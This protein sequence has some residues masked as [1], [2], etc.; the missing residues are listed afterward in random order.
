MN[1]CMICMMSLVALL[2]A[3]TLVGATPVGTA[4]TY[5]GVLKSGGAPV[6]GT[7][8][9]RFQLF[10]AMAGGTQIGA[11][12]DLPTAAVDSGLFSVDLDFG[13][14]PQAFNGSARW[15]Q[16]QVITNGGSTVTTLAP[17][18]PMNATPYALFAASVDGST[19]TN[20]NASNLASG[21]I[22]SAQLA[23][24]YAGALALTNPSNSIAGTF[25]GSGAGL[26][27]LNAS[28]LA[29]GT[30]SGSLLSGTYGNALTLSNA[31]NSFTGSGAGLTE[32]NASNISSGILAFER[33]PGGGAWPLSST[34]SLDS[35]T[36]AIDSVNNRVG[37]GTAVPA[38]PL[39][40]AQDPDPNMVL[41][42]TG[43]ASTQTGYVS[44]RNNTLTET[45]WIGFGNP[46]SPVFS[47]VNQRSGGHILL[48]PF[49]T[50]SNVGIGTSTPQRR[51]SVNGNAEIT[52]GDMFYV[53]VSNITF[54]G[55]TTFNDPVE[56]P[57][58][59][60]VGP[61]SST[62]VITLVVNGTA[63]KPGG[64]SWAVFSDRRLKKNIQPLQNSL[65]QLLAL[66][67]V[68]Y[69]YV[70]PESIN[71]RSGTRIGM[72]AQEVEKV[73]PDWVDELD[74]GYKSLT[75]RGFEALT[76]E[77]IRD[78]RAEKDAEIQ[79]LRSE[80]DELKMM[81]AELASSKQGAISK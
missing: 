7:Y 19:V 55:Q 41:H 57:A 1:R 29:A 31:G 79:S 49:N 3:P 50:S 72:I 46:G 17:R 24:T 36:L 76:V 5:Q 70:D 25:A 67:G 18:Q 27:S 13:A 59:L 10:D 45:G 75:F 38:G 11:A 81:I 58:H 63:A 21:T 39:H 60:H 28:N 74:D 37:I 48:A 69:Q 80:I 77:A 4:F 20:L 53:D 22:P 43:P 64:G 73:F 42:D 65:E 8:N 51:L 44:F 66:R 12:I 61:G 54:H 30:L 6:S 2:H 56:C 78:L 34:L 16:V 40:I 9:L 33:L 15:L 62:S 52:G 32:L 71:E 23:G 35:N 47:I 14:V 26:T 68:N